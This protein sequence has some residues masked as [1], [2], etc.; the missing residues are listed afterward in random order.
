M[1]AGCEGLGICVGVLQKSC[2]A[3]TNNDIIC[4]LQGVKVKMD[5]QGNILIK[6]VSKAGVFVKVSSDDNAV[7][8][9]ILKLPGC[10]LETEKPVMVRF[11]FYSSFIR[12]RQ[13]E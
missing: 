6:R 3:V 13:K 5:D 1:N 7:S 12:C 9:D 8:N 4:A 10:A 11:V 2:V